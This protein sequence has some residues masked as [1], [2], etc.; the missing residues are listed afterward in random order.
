MQQ[1]NWFDGFKEHGTVVSETWDALPSVSLEIDYNQHNRNCCWGWRSLPFPPQIDSQSDFQF[2]QKNSSLVNTTGCV[3]GRA[4]TTHTHI[5]ISAKF[6]FE[7]SKR[8][9]GI[10]FPFADIRCGLLPRELEK[11]P[12]ASKPKP[13]HLAE[14][15]IVTHLRYVSV[16]GYR[17][18]ITNI[19]HN[20][21]S[22][23]VVGNLWQNTCCWTPR[24]NSTS[25]SEWHRK[26]LD[27]WDFEAE[28]LVHSGRSP[29]RRCTDSIVNWLDPTRRL[30]SSF[31]F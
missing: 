14:A 2:R 15:L 9:G 22:P 26:Q 13:N 7:S 10:P 19:A 1:G 16:T 3:G 27:K 30:S 5:N 17:P 29:L 28:H 18:F 6:H 31:F 8:T 20:S 4:N 25:Q 23:S 11:S 21:L 24:T 12:F